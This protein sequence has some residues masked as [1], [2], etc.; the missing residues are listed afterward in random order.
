MEVGFALLPLS[1][2]LYKDATQ[3]QACK[4]VQT[5]NSVAAEIFLWY[6]IF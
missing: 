5:E 3:N 6:H 1:D 4:F 2:N